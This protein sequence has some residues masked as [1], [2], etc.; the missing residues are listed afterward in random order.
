MVA[1]DSLTYFFSVMVVSLVFGDQKPFWFDAQILL[2]CF[3]WPK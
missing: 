1:C 3:Y 2:R